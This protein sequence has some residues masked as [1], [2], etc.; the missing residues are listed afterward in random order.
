MQSLELVRNKNNVAELEL[1]RRL[2]KYDREQTVSI[3]NLDIEKIDV[4][5]FLKGVKKIHSDDLLE[6]RM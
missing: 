2:E 1:R 6:S 5:D 3:T 4:T